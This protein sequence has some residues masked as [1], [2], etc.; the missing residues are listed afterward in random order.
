VIEPP[1]PHLAIFAIILLGS[2]SQG[3]LAIILLLTGMLLAALHLRGLS[4]FMQLHDTIKG[5]ELPIRSTPMHGIHAGLILVASENIHGSIFSQSI[6]LIY[7]H[8]SSGSRGVI[9]N[10]QMTAD[11][12]HEN[13]CVTSSL[14]S[15]C[16]TTVPNTFDKMPMH[17]FGGPVGLPGEGARQEILALHGFGSISGSKEIHFKCPDTKRI[18]YGG[19][20]ADVLEEANQATEESPVM[21]FHG[22]STWGPGQLEGEIISGAWGYRVAS[23]N[24]I[25][26]SLSKEQSEEVWSSNYRRVKW[27]V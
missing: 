16:G 22:I 8:N 10:Q 4:M 17:F 2:R 13:G 12:D 18:Y 14:N 20:L 5:T 19:K 3:V 9:L 24:D 6:V 21:I 11:P 25:F 7:Q 26:V 27:L 1:W 23:C 15:D